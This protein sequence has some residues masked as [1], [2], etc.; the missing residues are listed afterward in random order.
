[1]KL[2]HAAVLLAA[3]FLAACG[4]GK[5]EGIVQFIGFTPV[6]ANDKDVRTIKAAVPKAP[7]V[8]AEVRA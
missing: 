8:A 4:G 3:S 6:T 1:M 5:Q 2:K 7:A